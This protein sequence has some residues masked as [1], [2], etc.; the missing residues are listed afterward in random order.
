M[1]Q[2]GNAALACAAMMNRCGLLIVGPRCSARCQLPLP[3]T[4]LYEMLTK[5]VNNLVD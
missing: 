5:T 2:T 1:A 3:Y 4:R